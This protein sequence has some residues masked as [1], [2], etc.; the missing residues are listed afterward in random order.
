MIMLRMLR[1]VLPLVLC[2]TLLTAC[3]G[4][5]PPPASEVP[6]ALLHPPLTP[7]L[8]DLERRTFDYFWET[9]DRPNALVPDRYPYTEAFSSIAA[10][11]FGLTAYAI[12]AERGWITREQARDRT[13]TTL[14]FFATAP[15]GPEPTG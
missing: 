13:L 4:P 3:S 2:L 1:V 5:P 7:L 12:G 10:V 6:V 8:E 15:Q 11:G 9:S 14:R